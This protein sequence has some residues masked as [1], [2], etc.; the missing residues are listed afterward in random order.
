[1]REEIMQL[2]APVTAQQEI[3]ERDNDGRDEVILE[4][5]KL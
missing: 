2:R 3:V 5:F 1:M 4:Q